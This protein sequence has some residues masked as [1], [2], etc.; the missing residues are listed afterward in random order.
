MKECDTPVQ[1]SPTLRHLHHCAYTARLVTSLHRPV[2]LRVTLQTHACSEFSHT[3]C[4]TGLCI[5]ILPRAFSKN[6]RRLQP[7]GK[8]ST[9]EGQFSTGAWETSCTGEDLCITFQI[10]FKRLLYKGNNVKIRL[11]FTKQI[12]TKHYAYFTV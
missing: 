12:L 7:S 4:K 11:Y 9:W 3:R 10:G 1:G 6:V 2:R 5:L 8:R